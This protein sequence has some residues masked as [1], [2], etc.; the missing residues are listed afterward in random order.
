MTALLLQDREGFDQALGELLVKR[1]K[2]DPRGL[3]RAV[4][5]RADGKDSLIDLLPK[6][7][8]AAERDLAEAAAQLL[9][10]PLVTARDYPGVPLFDDKLSARFLHESR[11]L[12]LT[13]DGDSVT[14][15]MA[16]PLDRYA[17]D[18]MRLIAGR[19][20]K[21][22]VAVPAELEAAIERLYGRNRPAA[23]ATAG[24]DVDI[25]DDSVDLDV[26]RLKDLASEAPVI[27]YVNQLI[28]RASEQAA[29]EDGAPRVWTRKGVGHGRVIGETP[30]GGELL[31]A[32]AFRARETENL[33]N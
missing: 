10:L 6:L 8:L 25:E 20:V 28:T 27:R 19:A 33:I 3:D 2:L 15:A 16:N 26:E 7:G 12:P 1:G 22:R 11:I 18:A 29:P 30:R 4:R 14:V 13:D 17:L 5:V 24:A 31:L 23:T 21:P 32:G 9:D